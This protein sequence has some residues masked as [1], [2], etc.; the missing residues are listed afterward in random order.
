MRMNLIFCSVLLVAPSFC[1]LAAAGGPI[2][3]FGHTPI[4]WNMANPIPYKIDQGTLGEFDAAQIADLVREAFSAWSEVPSAGVTK[5]VAADLGED[6]KSAKDYV[7]LRD[8]HRKGNLVLFDSTG[9]F[10]D[11]FTYKNGK[12]NILGWA[13]PYRQGNRI[14][15]FVS[16]FNGYLARLDQR[17]DL[18]LTLVHE[19]GH[20]L[21]LDHSQIQWEIVEKGLA[22]PDG[23]V[24]TMYPTSVSGPPK[25]SLLHMDDIAWISK[26]YPPKTKGAIAHGMLIGKLVQHDGAAVLGSNVVAISKSDD[27]L[28]FS[29]ASDWLMNNDGA[30][31]IPVVPGVY[32]IKVEPIRDGFDEGSSVGPYSSDPSG[33]AFVHPV[34]GKTFEKP[35]EIKLGNTNDIGE[36][37]S[38]AP[39]ATGN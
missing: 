38:P 31:A 1:S 19:F 21:G 28:R 32:T 5:F 26:L 11:D 16:L 18:R 3:L 39:P 35:V 25:Q 2:E 17:Q 8:D 36:L 4:T 24:P 7:R 22:D 9:E 23:Y 30:F 14:V 27:N 6:V 10:I 12:K 15:R 33:E 29:C 37:R 13:R 20:A 34:I